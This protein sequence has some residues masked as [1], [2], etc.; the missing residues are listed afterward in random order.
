MKAKLLVTVVVA[1]A[2]A[3]FAVSTLQR[4]SSL[5]AQAT[6][7]GATVVTDEY[8]NCEPGSAG[9][10]PEVRTVHSFGPDGS[11][12]SFRYWLRPEKRASDPLMGDIFGANGDSTHILGNVGEYFTVRNKIHTPPVTALNISGDCLEIAAQGYTRAGTQTVHGYR[13]VVFESKGA[14]DDTTVDYL[15]GLNCAAVPA[16]TKSAHGPFTVSLPVDIHEGFE[17]AKLAMAPAGMVEVAPSQAYRESA[18]RSLAMQGYSPQQIQDNWNK[19]IA[20]SPLDR[21]DQLWKE[22]LARK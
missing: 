15:P 1:L 17:P 4:T 9:C 16:R 14:M 20:N 10:A 6:F 13:A 5:Y 21:H 19:S 18:A 3:M 12:S 22:G 8:Y 7:K 11:R 2:V